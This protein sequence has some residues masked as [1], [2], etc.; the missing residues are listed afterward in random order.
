MSQHLQQKPVLPAAASSVVVIQE[1][2][3]PEADNVTIVYADGQVDVI[4]NPN[5]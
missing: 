5:R 2:A 3:P 4:G 1:K